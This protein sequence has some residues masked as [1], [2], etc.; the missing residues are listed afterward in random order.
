MFWHTKLGQVRRDAPFCERSTE[1]T[2]MARVVRSN[3]AFF[4][5]CCELVYSGHM[6][7]RLHG[8]AQKC[9]TV[10]HRV[11]PC[12]IDDSACYPSR[13][14][15]HIPSIFFVRLRH[16]GKTKRFKQVPKGPSLFIAQE[17]LDALP[18]HQFQYTAEGWREIL[19]DSKTPD[20][21]GVSDTTG[22]GV[23][24]VGGGDG[25]QRGGRAR[26]IEVISTNDEDVFR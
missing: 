19:V 23:A 6:N 17:F 7:E 21:G 24:I 1:G 5:S 4:S 2:G 18:V 25:G 9:Y 11:L 14:S 3:L 13:C 8:N 22:S 10:I 26:G 12:T 20:T 15:Y 16:C